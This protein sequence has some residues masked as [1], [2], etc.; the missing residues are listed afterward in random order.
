MKTFQL[1]TS[2]HAY[3]LLSHLEYNQAQEPKGADL[4]YLSPRLDFF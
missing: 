3:P 4:V 2:G 1:D